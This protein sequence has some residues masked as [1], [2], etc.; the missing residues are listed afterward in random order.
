MES[1]FKKRSQSQ[2]LLLVAKRA[3]E[4]YIEQDEKMAEKY[5]TENA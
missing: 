4:I 5:I 1:L 2:N 3:V